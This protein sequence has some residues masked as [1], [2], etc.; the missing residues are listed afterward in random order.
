MFGK[1]LLPSFHCLAVSSHAEEQREKEGS[2]EVS[3][4]KGNKVLIHHEILLSLLP[5]AGVFQM[6]LGSWVQYLKPGH[7]PREGKRT[8]KMAKSDI[9]LKQSTTQRVRQAAEVKV[10]FLGLGFI[11]YGRVTRWCEIRAFP[12]WLD[13]YTGCPDMRA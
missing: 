10:D 4:N 1:H 2:F 13:Y 11:Q 9:L 5:V 12:K 7:C 3:S 6:F 8:T